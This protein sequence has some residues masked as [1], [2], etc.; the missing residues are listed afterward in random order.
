MKDVRLSG[1]KTTT[2]RIFL[3]SGDDALAERDFFDSLVRDGVNAALM[4]LGYSV[5]FEVDRWERS[6]PHKILLGAS[7]NDEFVERAK[8]ANLVVSVLIDNLGQGTKEELEAALSE[9]SIE[10]SIVWCEARDAN[11]DTDVSRWLLGHQGEVFYDRAGRPETDGP[12]VALGRLITEATLTAL[13]Q[14]AP[15]ELMHE[16]R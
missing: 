8:C 9:G 10:L 11:P 14:Y 2:I 7:P 15:E 13:R 5:R 3:S 16:A 1:S 4:N 12:R 6:A